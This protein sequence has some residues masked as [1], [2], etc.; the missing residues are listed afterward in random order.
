MSRLINWS[1]LLRLGIV[2][3]YQ[4]EKAILY[5]CKAIAYL[6]FRHLGQ[7]FMEPSDFYDSPIFLFGGVGPNPH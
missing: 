6:R 7:F 4:T 1:I 2:S 3:C 5:D